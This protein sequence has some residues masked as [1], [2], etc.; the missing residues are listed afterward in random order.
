VTISPKAAAASSCPPAFPPFLTERASL[1]T[2][3]PGRTLF[4]RK[5]R[6]GQAKTSSDDDDDDSAILQLVLVHGLCATERQFAPLLQALHVQLLEEPQTQKDNHS[7]NNNN[8]KKKISTIDCL[9]YDWMGCGQSRPIL[10]EW[11]AYDNREGQEDLAALLTNP[12]FLSPSRP[13]VI[14]GH[15][16]APSLFFPLLCERP[17]SNL[18]A[19]ILLGTAVQTPS[20]RQPNGGAWI[21]RLPLFLLRCLQPLLS[22]AFAERAVHADHPALRHEIVAASDTNDMALAQAYHGHIQWA[23]PDNAVQAVGHVPC[24]ILHG[25]DDG[26]IPI[27]AGQELANL[28]L[29]L[30]RDDERSKF[31]AMERT[32]HLLMLEDPDRVAYEIRSFLSTM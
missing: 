20:L 27:A 26:I 2:V 12:D 29:L 19:C 17:Q 10:R 24:L 30:S 6:L 9:L 11:D 25:V 7:S 22:K 4:V 18:V 8:S 14:L 13:L 23:S 32:S 16:Y 1:V 3:R 31:V 5:V 15:S 28:L 21:M